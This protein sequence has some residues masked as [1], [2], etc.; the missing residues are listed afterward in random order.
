MGEP[1][2]KNA[3]D[4]AQVKRAGKHDKRKAASFLEDLRAVM[5]APV[6]RSFV[7]A[8]I[9]RSGIY[10]SAFHAN[11]N[12]VYFTIGRQNFGQQ[13]LADAIEAS[14]ELYQLMEREARETQRLEDT[15][16]DAAH[17]KGAD[18]NEGANHE[19]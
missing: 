7:W 11:A 12:V 1:A 4:P 5:S 18:D 17:I 15:A 6:G 8:L 16:R 2:V 3:A 13:L 10:S 19:A 14:T 9:S